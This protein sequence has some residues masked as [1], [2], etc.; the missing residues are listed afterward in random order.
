[1]P[2]CASEICPTSPVSTTSDSMMMVT[3]MLVMIPKR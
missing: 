3:I 2:A 1:M